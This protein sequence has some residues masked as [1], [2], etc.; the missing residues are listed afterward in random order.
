VLVP[1][2]VLTIFTQDNTNY[3]TSKDEV[4]NLGNQLNNQ[5]I[6]SNGS[7]PSIKPDDSSVQNLS[8]EIKEFQTTKFIDDADIVMRDESQIDHLD[9]TFM[10]AN[11]TQ[12]T[13]QFLKDFLKKPIV[14]ASGSFNI[15]DTYSFLSS[16]SMPLSAFNSS[17]GGLWLNKLFGY[18]G[19]R[20]DMRFRIVVNA[21]KFQQG[22]YILGWVPLGGTTRTTS[23]IKATLFNNM[24][25]ATLTQR[26]T[27]PHV[28]I[29]LATQTSAELLIPFAS[30]QNY[31]PIS[32]AIS[33]VDNSSLGFINLYPYSPLVA[34][35]GSTVASYTIYL[36]LENVQLFG[37]ASPQSARVK[38]QEISNKMNG[39][40][41]GVATAFAKGFKEFG[42]IPLLSDYALGASWIADRVANVAS[43]F[44]WA[45]PTQGDSM[46]KIMILNNPGHCN[47]DG[48]SEVKT[49]SFLAQPATV[50]LKGLAGTC[51]DEMD[52]SYIVRKY[53]FK[54]KFDWSLG[55]APGNLV[56]INVTP[57][58]AIPGLTGAIVF[59]PVNFVASFF[60]FWRGSLKYRFKI[61]KTEFHSGR[62]QVCFYP[63]DESVFTAD[64]YYVNRQIIDIRDCMEFE[65]VIP[66]IS[67]TPYL[68]VDQTMGK[69]SID[70]VDSLVAPASVSSSVTFLVE[71]CGG[72][73]MEFA[74]PAQ[75][76]FSAKLATP[77][78]AEPGKTSKQ[79]SFNIGNSAISANP[80]NASAYCIGDKVSN[81]RE[82]LKR[83]SYIGPSTTGSANA[84]RS[85]KLGAIVVPD[86]IMA[87][88]NGTITVPSQNADLISLVGSCY[89]FW[90]GG[91]RIKDIYDVN[92]TSLA[93][94]SQPNVTH[95]IIS[96][97]LSQKNATE[98]QFS[99]QAGQS[100][101]YPNF[102]QAMQSA[103]VNSTHVVEIPQYTQNLC[104]NICDVIVWQA[105]SLAVTSQYI[106]GP[107]S[108]QYNVKFTGPVLFGDGLD[109][110][111]YDTHN[112][113]RSLSDDGNFSLFISVPP[114]TTYGV[115]APAG[116]Y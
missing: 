77:Q 28:E 104:R 98:K 37:A 108:T 10:Y 8:T 79:I 24:H 101:T 53:A 116:F 111:F 54:Q 36:S 44:G 45:K 70:I 47:V 80:V 1:H 93:I 41:S 58:E 5:S 114:L 100:S 34:P 107:S 38:K 62:I 72:D 6:N 49:L 7:N 19:M 69:L 11:D 92:A 13:E 18:F 14:F 84:A 66:Y 60:R 55:T 22:R 106:S 75:A 48:D 63:T 112:L 113:Y 31:W 4:I 33:N 43:I 29:D 67:R 102:H 87:Y 71:T 2:N 94:A 52:F 90:S 32:S 83:W 73:D 57:N 26:T 30:T 40:V 95:N 109:T 23:N 9:P 110:L 50:P 64:P 59:T 86:I 105:D 46:Q 115:L 42:A 39:P 78:S 56:M 99:T 81:F 51:Y 85:N 25:M 27:V 74:V 96:S 68:T 16:F 88:G 97:V 76:N 61:V 35:T 82:Y 65:V 21:N 3:S 17:S 91:V 103:N 89:M 20:F 12:L 15:T